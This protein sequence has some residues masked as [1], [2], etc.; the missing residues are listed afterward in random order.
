M[1]LSNHRQFK[2]ITYSCVWALILVTLIFVLS[3][4]TFAATYG[5][6]SPDN[7]VD[8]SDISEL[9]TSWGTS[10]AS[11]ASADLNGDGSINILDL[12]ILLSN[13]EQ[14]C[15]QNATGW[16]A[17]NSFYNTPL[18]S[19]VTVNPSSSTWLSDIQS[20]ASDLY[21]NFNNWSTTI[22]T[23]NSSTP[24]VNVS[25]TNLGG[26]TISIPYQS[27]WLP[28]PQ[29]D[30][31]IVVIDPVSGCDYEFD[32]FNPSNL[33]AN[34]FR[35][36]HIYTGSGAHIADAGVSGGELSFLGG[37]ITPQD[38]NSGSINHALGYVTNS[39]SPDFVVPGTRSD[40]TQ[41]GGIP[42]GQ[43]MRLDPSINLSSSSYGLDAFQIMVAK[44][45]QTYGAYDSDSGGFVTSTEDTLDGS[46]YNIAVDSTALPSTLMSHL[47]FINFPFST[48]TYDSNTATSCNV[49]Q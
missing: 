5:C 17:S 1:A 36:F 29:S 3:G 34:A 12:S 43:L 11:D 25:I 31:H 22:Y 2:L 47:Q 38:V 23:A 48:P 9:T 6:L 24:N 49:P 35:S 44:A 28:D 8:S 19:N 10:N 18:P 45:L 46:S 14:S 4:H 30:A 42:E 21:N 27:S 39:N 37:L 32:G 15:R 20:Y 13:Y 16:W 33:T 7:S 26:K 41:V 40:G